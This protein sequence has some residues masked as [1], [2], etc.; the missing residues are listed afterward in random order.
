MK[1]LR[2][3]C[4]TAL[5]ALLTASC[6]PAMADLP[7]EITLPCLGKDRI[8]KFVEYVN[9]GNVHHGRY[10]CTHCGLKV[11]PYSPREA[12]T[13][14]TATCTELAV[15]DVCKF[16][17]GDYAHEL[18]HHEAKAATCTEIGWKAY[19]TCTKCDYTTYVEIPA[20]GHDLEHHE[21]KAATCTEIGWKEYDT[22]KNCDYTT[23]VEIPA[24]G[25]ALE[26]HE[27][28]AAT[29][30]EVGWNEYDTCKNCD[31]TTYVEIPALG[32]DYQKTIVKPTCEKDGYT[33]FNCTRCEDTYT[34]NPVKKL[35]HWYGE[36]TP[37]G[38]GT[39]SAKCLRKGC[40]HI[41]KTDCQKFEFVT[42]ENESL[43]FCPV[44]GEV[45]NGTRL[46]R[47]EKAMAVAET[48]KLPAGELIA[49]MNEAY[50]SLAFE[51]AGKVAEPMGRV[52]ITLPAEL[53]DGKKLTAIALDGTETEVTPELKDGEAS[54]T[55]DFAA[56]EMPVMLIRLT[57]AE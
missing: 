27:A 41:G 34:E 3:L 51:Y 4:L 25:H 14:G 6:L 2:I 13:G 39:H 53:L 55:L 35:H 52:K 38:D 15:C 30:T 10:Q 8:H 44:C 40:R 1:K 29:C 28:K 37:N 11:I 5:I 50:L 42:A 26:H 19:D 46:E 22:C 54:F 20:P 7:A 31:Y 56:D 16:E 23:Y 48:E 12:H 18:E 57:D 17:Y 32:H 45:E 47:I 24:S 43:I 49:R 9:I 21:A 33:R 36:W